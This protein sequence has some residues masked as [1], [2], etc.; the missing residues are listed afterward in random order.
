MLSCF[1][2]N[3]YGISCK[4]NSLLFAVTSY[5]CYLLLCCCRYPVQIPG[6]VVR[7][8]YIKKFFDLDSKQKLRLAPKLKL[9]HL[10]LNNFKTMNVRLAAQVFSHSVAVG[11]SFYMGIDHP[12]IPKDAEHTINFLL[13]MDKIFYSFNAVSF[14]DFKFSRRPVTPRSYHSEFWKDSVEWLESVSFVGSKAKIYCVDGFK[15]SLT[16]A[17]CLWD[18]LKTQVKFMLPRRL[19]QDCLES[20]FSSIRQKG[21]FRDNPSA[22]HFRSAMRQCVA[23]KLLSAS[24]GGNCE[25]SAVSSDNLLLSLQYCLAKPA[26]SPGPSV[27]SQTVAV[28]QPKISVSSMCISAEKNA[29]V[30]V[31]GYVVYRVKQKHSCDCCA[32]LCREGSLDDTSLHFI[33]LKAICSG[34]F[35]RLQVPSCGVIQFLSVV[36]STFV[37]LFHSYVHAPNCLSSITNELMS[38]V[39]ATDLL[40]GVC[41]CAVSILTQVYLRLRMHAELPKLLTVLTQKKGKKSAGKK[42]RKLQ[43]RSHK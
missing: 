34:T 22:V 17:G 27:S 12:D 35:G 36:E 9:V 6:G 13:R 1:R 10:L 21:G 40:S 18:D 20:F 26:I 33:H 16:V 14:K 19:N 41:S 37:S 42:S 3:L 15:L 8:Y 11:L 7:W 4:K 24:S 31:A 30:Y 5:T 23:N 29:L 39:S 2:V 43:K 25:L 28:S 38:S 32:L